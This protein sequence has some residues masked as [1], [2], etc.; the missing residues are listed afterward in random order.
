MKEKV[1]K[2]D[3]FSTCHPI[4]NLIYFIC[5][6]GYA[7]AFTDPVCLGISFIGMFI[8]LVMLK[9]GSGIKKNLIYML[10]LVVIT[11]GINM[12]FSHQG[13]TILCYLPSGN[14]L[15]LE[16][17]LY[18]IGIAFMIVG[19]IG[20]FSCFNEVITS[21]KMIYLFGSLAPVLSLLISMVLRFNPECA[22]RYREVYGV[23][24]ASGYAGS[25]KHFKR[26]KTGI[27]VSSVVVTWAL[28]RAV[29][30]ADSMLSRGY[31]LKKRTAYSLFVWDGRD[32]VS[33]IYLLITGIYVLV[34]AA[35][36]TFRFWY[37]PA[38]TGIKLTPYRLSAYIM[39]ALMVVCPLIVK[40]G[41]KWIF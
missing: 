8:Y 7:M 11:A 39:Y 18:G 24:K 13:V 22:D 3:T 38:V 14:P 20:W 27:K 23:I 1:K 17:I 41:K 6:I 12:A 4:V 33:L 2:K 35:N 9:G 25:G 32:T 15:T 28:E 40:K 29:V 34:A 30:T 36:G 16:S 26:L 10:F 5:V 21:N 19:T 37:Y 31:G